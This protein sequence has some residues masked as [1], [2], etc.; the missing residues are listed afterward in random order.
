ME[1]LHQLSAVATFSGALHW[2][3]IHGYWLMFLAML[4]EGPIVTSAASFAF[5]MGYFNL[6]TIFI[7]S[8]VGNFVPDI[9]YYGIG[10][11]GRITI[12][13]RLGAKFSLTKERIA[14]MEAVIR[15]HAWKTLVA[16]KLMPIIPVPGLML[17]G[18]TRMPFKKYSAISFL[19]GIPQTIFFMVIGY[20]FGRTYDTLNKY[21]GYG[22]L[23]LVIIIAAIILVY[24]LYKR[25]ATKLGENI[26]KF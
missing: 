8:T 11:W 16:I 14:G 2:V 10:Y 9:I 12:V 13:E 19:T 18:A 22:E 23:L 6:T 24:M 15:N 4:V 21:F 20:Y 25:F 17:V 5:A 3:L 7:L 26:Q 1:L